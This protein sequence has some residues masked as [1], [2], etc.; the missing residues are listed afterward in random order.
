VAGGLGSMLALILRKHP[1]LRGVLFDLPGV[2]ARAHND[3]HVTA[4][5]IAGR[6]TLVAGDM[7]ESVPKD[8]DAY[9]LKYILHNWDDEHCLRI[10][11]NC[12]DAMNEKGRILIA[13]PVIP[14]G[15]APGW[16]KLLDIQMMVVVPGKE[17]TREE[18]AA[19]FARAG[20]RLTRIITT[21][22]P[23]SLVEGVR[24]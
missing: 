10:L 4:P 18:F 15:D 8:A 13:D 2:I 17:R 19:L 12:R 14:P 21:N 9:L 1:K 16:G 7:F 24:A 11:T 23:V 22:C 3:T 20:L 5:G 6:C